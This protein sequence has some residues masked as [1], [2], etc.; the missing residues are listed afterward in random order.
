[1]DFDKTDRWW[2]RENEIGT[3]EL[4]LKEYFSRFEAIFCAGAEAFPRT[5]AQLSGK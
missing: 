2:E 3:D 5:T 4:C 1:M